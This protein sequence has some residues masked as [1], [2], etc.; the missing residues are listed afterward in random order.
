MTSADF[1]KSINAEWKQMDVVPG[2]SV[3]GARKKKQ[4]A[5]M[6]FAGEIV[7]AIIAFGAALFFWS[8]QLG[9]LFNFSGLVLFASGLHALILNHRITRPVIIWSDWSP[10]GVIEYQL[11]LCNSA[12]AKARYVIF[13]CIALTLFTAFIWIVAI[14]NRDLVPENFESLYS[15]FTLPIVIG[16]VL[17]ARWRLRN[18]SNEL[19]GYQE[20]LQAFLA[21]EK[22]GE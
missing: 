19:A 22:N 13:S 3:D 16:L 7:L 1:L 8:L 21:A 10:Q 4:L 14:V 12:M 6:A 17:W 18:K 15:A 20:L 5:V 11:E 9:F 2:V